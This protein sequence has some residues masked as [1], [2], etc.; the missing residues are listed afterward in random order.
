MKFQVYLITVFSILASCTKIDTTRLGGELIPVVDN[1][2]TFDTILD[3]QSFNYIPEDSTRIFLS[4]PHPAGG[5]AVDPLFGASKATLFFEMKPATFPFSFAPTDSIVGFDSAVLILTFRGY[6]GDSA[7]PVNYKLFEVD[8]K[9]QY[10]TVV[11]PNYTLNPDLAAN[12]SKFWG[13]KTMAPNRYRDTISIK[14]GDSVYARVTNQL[15]IPLNSQLASKLFFQ[16]AD[17]SAGAFKSD[18]LF[19]EYLP[20]FALT[21]EQGAGSLQYFGLREASSQVTFY[22][23]TKIVGRIDTTSKGFGFSSRS[24]HAVK[25]ERNRAGA[26]INNFLQ[27]DPQKGASQIYVQTAPYTKVS[28]KIPGL[29]TLTNRIIHRAELRLVELTPNNGPQSQLTAP[30]ILYLDVEEEDNNFKGVPLDLT[31]LTNYFCFPNG[32]IEFFYFGGPTRTEQIS[33]ET[34]NVYRFNIARHVQ[35]II[36]RQEQIFNFRVSAP[37]YMV[38]NNCVNSD[39][40]VPSNY[41]FLKNTNGAIP[42][43]PG[44]GRIRLAGG[45]HPDVNKRMQLRVIYSKL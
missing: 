15:R 35:G 8:R 32:R 37:Y 9:M 38:Y 20:G 42:N 39:F 34:L 43:I 18:S 5:I 16:A 45:S 3:V 41:F 30:P 23:R 36:T 25:F 10:D 26:E 2:N 24:G 31:P 29:K 40:T 21:A 13:A 6:Y 17:T 33:G 19:R 27:A 11:R 28:V 14:R 22:Y 7:G 4:E 44:N 1:I 12:T